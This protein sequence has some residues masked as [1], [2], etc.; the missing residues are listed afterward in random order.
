MRALL[1]ASLLV[2]ACGTDDTYLV[3]SV[4]RR[5]AVHDAD[6][7]KVTLSNS[8]TM[9]TK[10][11]DINDAM[12]PLTF[13]L[14]AP[15]RSGDLT[16]G[17]DA[18]DVMGTLVGRGSGTT[19]LDEMTASVMIDSA[20]F[21]VN[22]ELAND[23]FLTTD[24][25][26][27]GFQLAAISNGQWTATYRDECT[28]CNIYGRRFD[29]TGLP[30]MSAIAAGDIGF[31]VSTTQTTGG[32]MSAVASTGLNTV[33]FWDYTDTSGAPAGRGIACRALNENGA[34]MA[35]Q[36]TVV[37]P[38]ENSDVVSAVG[39][40]NNNFAV[41]W[42]LF[43]SPYYVAR[44]A[45]VTKDCALVAGTLRDASTVTTESAQRPNVTVNANTLLYSWIVPGATGGVRVRTAQLSGTFNGTETTLV[46]NNAAQEIEHARVSP[47]GTGFAVAVRWTSAT[48]TDGP[49]KIEVYRTSAT[50]QLQGA[51][52]L[53]TDKSRSD[54]ASNKGFS[55]AQRPDGALLVV[56][57]VC[58]TGPGLCDVFGRI[59]RPTG[60][61]VGDEFVIPTSVASE[62]INPSVVALQDSFVA[63]WNDSSGEAPDRSG[64]AVRA[65]ILY[66]VYD[67][68]RGIHGATCGASSP[69]APACAEGLACAMGSDGAQRCYAKCT[70]PSCPGGGTCSTVDET[71]SACTF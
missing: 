26:A 54:F 59:L 56:W 22:T 37:G 1:L 34:G 60:A 35:T 44:T 2:S 16:I 25:E 40:S 70:P 32:A 7:L 65:R 41:V 63:A 23:Q 19:K 21:V 55:I 69:G 15:G 66:P 68:A 67:D 62:Q 43:S 28:M 3:V 61:P 13:S 71:T 52:I 17:I 12:F 48:D 30:V 45:I 33:V 20:D 6:K 8:G 53:I 5:A 57:H 36:A 46:A 9:L 14:S 31:P 29:S 64:T 51:P 38:T 58:E 10:E 50:G 18:V 47:W 49:G 11:L 24:F 4:D 27:V 39:M 42:Q